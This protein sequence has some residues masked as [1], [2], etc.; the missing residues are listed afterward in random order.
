MWAQKNSTR[1]NS[2]ALLR[3]TRTSAHKITVTASGNA[4]VKARFSRLILRALG[5][6]VEGEKPPHTRY[7]LIAAP[8]TSNWDFPMMILFA[9]AFGIKISWMGK[10]SLFAPPFGWIMRMLGGI[11]VSRDGTTRLVDEMVSA[12]SRRENL[13]LV[14]P[15]EGTRARTEYWKSGFYHIAR[16]AGVPI[17]PS[18]LDFGEKRGGFG[19]PLEVSGDVCKDMQHLRTFYLPMR[20]LYPDGFGPV[21][22][23]EEE[24]AD[25]T[26]AMPAPRENQRE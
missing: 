13:V 8:H 4:T 14:V 16:G 19:P 23:R 17:V 26:Q 11:P 18:Y 20:G 12:F 10:A 24:A 7:V 5:W 3:L 6:R 9:W 22:L 1:R 25:Q 21:R 2:R 15:T